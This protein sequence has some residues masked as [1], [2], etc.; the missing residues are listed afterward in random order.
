METNKINSVN[1]IDFSTPCN[2]LEIEKKVGSLG[3]SLISESNRKFF[4]Q[5]QYNYGIKCKRHTSI[6]RKIIADA[7]DEAKEMLT[8]IGEENVLE[9]KDSPAETVFDNNDYYAWG[10]DSPWGDCDDAESIW[11]TPEELKIE[12]FS[13]EKSKR[14]T[15]KF[16]DSAN[17]I[18]FKESVNATKIKTLA[19]LRETMD[20]SW[21]D[22]KDYR[23]VKSLVELQ[24]YVNEM[25]K[26][27][28]IGMDTET[29]GLTFANVSKDNPYRSKLVGI[30]L[31][32]KEDMAIYV[33]VEH[34]KFK[35]LPL[36]EVLLML[37]PILEEKELITHNGLFDAKVFYSL[38]IKCNIAHDTMLI[39]F[40]IDCEPLRGTRKLK[41]LIEERFGYSPLEFEDIFEYEKD[42]SLFRYADEDVVRLYACADADHTLILFK[43]LIEELQ[44]HQLRGYKKDI[45][46]LPHLVRSEYEGK[47]LNMEILREMNR[48]NDIDLQRVQDIIFK[49]VGRLYS[50]LNYGHYNNEY[51]AFN[52]SSGPELARLCFRYFGYPFSDKKKDSKDR[53]KIDK[54]VL[55]FWN[56]EE[57]KEGVVEDEAL[58]EIM[59]SVLPDNLVSESSNSEILEHSSITIL[60]SKLLASKRYPM[61]ML[62]TTYR[63]LYKSKTSFFAPLLN[64]S[65]ESKSFT[66]ISMIKAATYRLID[67]M[68]TL[69]KSLK[70]IVCPPEGYY[71]LGYDYAQIEAR[72]M[73]G[74][75]HDEH[76]V[77]ELDNPE[78]D[79][80][81][82]ATA[83]ILK[84]RPEEVS[85]SERKRFKSVNFGIP[86]GLGP[87]GMLE[88]QI[89]IGL[90]EKEY[91]VELAKIEATI[92]QW[93]KGMWRVDNMLNDYRRKTHVE[94]PENQ[95]PW[96]LRG[97]KVGKVMNPFG[98]VR[99]FNLDDMTESRSKSI[100]RQA[101]NFPI[102]SFARDI[103]VEGVIRLGNRFVKER[104]M[105]VKVPDNYSPLGFHF[106]NRIKFA[107]YIH[108][109]VQMYVEK[110][111]NAKWV[112]RQI[113]ECC[114]I[115]IKGHPTYYVGA[116]IV[117]NWYESKAG[118]HEVPIVWLQNLGD[119]PKF[120]PY[121][122]TLQEDIDKEIREYIKKRTV[123]DFKA[124]GIDITKDVTM[125]TSKL[126]EFTNYYLIEKITELFKA[127]RKI[128]KS[129]K[130]NYNDNFVAHLEA[131]FGISITISDAVVENGN[132]VE[133]EEA[134]TLNVFDLY[135][136]IQA[137][138]DGTLDTSSGE[139]EELITEMV[140]DV[141]IVAPLRDKF[142]SMQDNVTS[143]LVLLRELFNSENKSN[144]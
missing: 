15:E 121:S 26:Y 120:T 117:N 116:G 128:I 41:G 32:W 140:K 73:T 58:R 19:Q 28:F 97:H 31:A 144:K 113:Y 29:T 42:Y 115:H 106:E 17:R 129:D 69:D 2:D 40:N 118:D 53:Y 8:S 16:F 86:Y 25:K 13:E 119:V 138:Q 136:V 47:Y 57:L 54:K 56:K 141:Q 44:P 68:Q 5:V 83:S 134:E 79:Y 51:Y 60:D 91:K 88:G 12:E 61:S 98:R 133:V 21:A 110:G 35:S 55:K 104:L 45:E 108:D 123:D 3:D 77:K 82:L 67:K 126:L 23:V 59:L 39:Q 78:S 20:L 127:N 89:G 100:D 95:I 76:F 1:V 109:E 122:E 81:R 130:C 62:I 50:Y 84:C 9:E 43:K 46:L 14:Q 87:Q 38:G 63:K 27:R 80:H 114:V 65:L 49:Y 101:G 96:T 36:R 66:S 52:I 6:T 131:V 18:L 137:E 74:L 124:I 112:F 48:V 143:N 34:L 135:S 72:V 132:A 139:Y 33:P 85:S 75:A 105:D 10:S 102:Q 103:F 125:S 107:A 71:M 24:D 11:G 30:C 7:E 99:Y 111:I 142:S 64:E 92:D 93:K 90:S 4:E 94:I 22:K 37:K 70:K